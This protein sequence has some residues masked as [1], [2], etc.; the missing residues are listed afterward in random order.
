M[1]VISFLLIISFVF[2]LFHLFAFAVNLPNFVF[3]IHLAC[4]VLEMSN[5]VVLVGLYYHDSGGVNK[6]ILSFFVLYS[7]KTFGEVVG[8]TVRKRNAFL[9][10]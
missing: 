1:F 3:T 10:I 9:S 6:Q 4:A 8:M 5:S 7:S 2:I